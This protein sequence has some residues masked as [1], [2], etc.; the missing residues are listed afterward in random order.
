[1][2]LKNKLSDASF[3]FVLG[4]GVAD[5]DEYAEVDEDSFELLRFRIR[6]IC[7]GTENENKRVLLSVFVLNRDTC[8]G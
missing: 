2:L 8:I 1:M 6:D 7:D 3:A 4:G 5:C